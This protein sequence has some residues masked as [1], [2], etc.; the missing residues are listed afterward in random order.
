MPQRRILSLWFPRLA[1]ERALRRRRLP[2]ALPFAVVGERGGAQV[3]ASL[4]ALAEG[5]GLARGQPLRDAMAMCPRLLTAAEDRAGDAAFLT[6][7]MRW[8]GKF[9]PWV[10]EERPDALVVD[11]TGCAH[12]FG[13]EEALLVQVAGDCTALGLTVR[14]GIADTV[15]AAWA[16]ARF[17]GGPVAT[18]SGARTGDAI[19]QEAH[20]TRSRAHPRRRPDAGGATASSGMIAPTGRLRQVLGPL[21]LAALRLD[22]AAVEGLSRLGLR[23]VE[24]I[25]LLPRAALA[26]RFGAHVLR[27]LDQALG[28]DPEPVT[29][30][31]APL[32]FA[33]R[34]SLPDP[35]GLL[36]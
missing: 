36:A 22:G 27:R 21:P 14:A 10:A 30:A 1:A 17:A 15:G 4:E 16:L 6:A 13:G 3:L 18:A 9:S 23:R 33:A 19:A 34:L 7:L 8:A 12:L 26:R 5:A 32:H 25:A 2:D 11:L 35:I 20:A 24:D 29:P 28:L 31:G